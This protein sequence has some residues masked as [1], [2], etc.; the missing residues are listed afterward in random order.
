[1]GAELTVTGWFL[2]P[3]IRE[4]QDT[5][6]AYIKGQFSWKKDQEKDL[7]R[8][9]ITLTEILTIVDVI[10]KREINNVNQ[11]IL[12]GKLKDAIYSAVDVLDSFQYMVLESKVDNQSAVSCITSSCIYLGKRLVGTDNFRRNL[13]DILEKLGEV[14]RAADTLL[15]VV[16]LD[17]AT[18][19]L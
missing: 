1:M 4:M 18:A 11:R 8:L 17:N 9:D 7:E 3:I 16:S 19:K 13:A 12:L 5:A 6:L 10:E 2:S 14:R 15:K